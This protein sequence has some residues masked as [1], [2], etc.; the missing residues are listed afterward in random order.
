MAPCFHSRSGRMVTLSNGNRTAERIRPLQEFNNGLVMSDE[1]LR[2]NQLF[3]VRIDRKVDTWS[4]SIEIGV[5]TQDPSSLTFPTSATN[6]REGSWVMSGLSVLQDGHSFLEEYG[7]D[8]D[9]LKEGERVGV[10]RTSSGDLQFFVNGRNLGAAA[11]NIPQRVFAVIDMYGKCAQVTLI[12]S[13]EARLLANEVSNEYIAAGQIQS[14][15]W[16]SRLQFHE[17]CGSLVKLSNNNRTAERKKPADEFNNGVV[18]TNRPLNEDELFQIRIDELVNNWS[19]S[20]EVGVTTHCPDTLEF[21]ATMTNMRSGTVMMSG[22]GILTNGKSSNQYYGKFNLDELHEGDR[23]GLMRKS[24]GNLHYYI[25]ELDQGIA[26]SDIPAVVYG[27]VDLYGMTVK[28]TIV[29]EVQDSSPEALDQNFSNMFSEETYLPA[30]LANSQELEPLLFHERCGVHAEITNNGR[31]ALRPNALEDFNNAV[32]LTNRP[33]RTAEMFEVI[34]EQQVVKWTGSIE[35]GVTTHSPYDIEFPS[36]MTN[37]RSGTWMM[38]G[39]GIMCNGTSVV[40]EYGINLERLKIGDR[41]GVLLEPDGTLHF[42]VN[43]EDQGAAAKCVAEKLYGVIDL[44]GQAAQVSIV[45]CSEQNTA[46]V[47]AT[48]LIFPSDLHFHQLHGRNARL[49]NQG[50]SAVRPNALAEFNDAIVMTNRPLREG[51][52]FQVLIDK[53]VD[54]WSGSI[55]AGVTTIPP[56]ALQF[57]STMTDIKHDTWML[58]GSAVMQDGK[59]IRDRY[60]CDLDSLKTG[61]RI[62]MMRHLD[63]TLHY[64]VN[65]ED[66]GIACRDVPPDVYAVID[67]YGQCAQVTIVH[68]NHTFSSGSSSTPF[69]P[70]SPQVSIPAP[71][72]N[73]RTKYFSLCFGKNITLRENNTAATRVRGFSHGLLFSSAPLDP[74]EVFEVQVDQVNLLWAGHLSVGLT[75]LVPSLAISPFYLPA[76]ANLLKGSDTWIL[77]DKQ[78]KKNGTVLKDNY[79]MSLRCLTVGDKVGVQCRNDGS[80]HV[81]INGEDQ[82]IAAANLPK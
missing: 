37:M 2:D 74:G 49:L 54:R 48:A 66:Q 26:A 43:G 72:G 18:M 32:A 82:G 36:T 64:Y 81:Y 7:S 46:P 33:L 17:H 47:R 45:D 73:E 75:T 59:T 79:C 1:P 51:E 39:S 27:V 9:K 78:V 80:F 24:N 15:T 35:I 61:T 10:M 57:P 23:I 65:N 20:I 55:E 56:A 5:T 63:G 52:M 69:T 58:S 11:T 38:T 3:E 50:L 71:L 13:T 34:L 14:N 4:G 31:T 29:D 25:N 28:V 22:C 77:T 21:P 16:E 62:G 40:E 12:D 44:Y 67:L 30:S 6:L 19:G 53:M 70:E 41:V 76:S 8:L 60:K 68:S 42:Y